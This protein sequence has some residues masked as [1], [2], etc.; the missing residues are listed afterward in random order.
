MLKSSFEV[1][2]GIL[3]TDMPMQNITFICGDREIIRLA[4][5]GD[6][7]IKGKLIE[8]DRD[9]VE[10]LRHFLRYYKYAL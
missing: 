7:Y 3:N 10:G 6:I 4:P 1:K 8:N 9:V 5:N 2:E